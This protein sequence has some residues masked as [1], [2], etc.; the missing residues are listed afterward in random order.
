MTD[1]ASIMKMKEQLDFNLLL[2][3]GHLRVSANTLGLKYGQECDS[4]RNYV[5]WIHV[6]EN[7]GIYDEHKPLNGDSK[8]TEEFCKIFCPDV[9]VTLETVGNIEEI[10][11]SMEILKYMMI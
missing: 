9:N 8:I 7:N 3:L 4:L 2:D 11:R 6:S 1:C 5:Q 10:L